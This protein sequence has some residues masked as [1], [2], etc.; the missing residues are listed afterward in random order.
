MSIEEYQDII[1]P[2]RTE[3]SN[4]AWTA[5]T[6]QPTVS[7]KILPRPF[8]ESHK[9]N[10][11]KSVKVMELIKEVKSRMGDC[12]VIFV[13]SHR[14]YADFIIFSYILF[15]YDIEI[16]AIAAGMDFHG[17]AGVG[18]MLRNTGAFFMRRTYN[19]DTL[20]WASFK[21]YVNSLVSKGDLPIEF[22]IEGTRSRSNKS[23]APKYGLI[24]MVLKAYFLKQVPD[25]M[26]V[27]VSINYDRILEETLFAFELL[28]I[29]KP[30][31][32]TS[33][34]FKSL[35]IVKERYGC[36]YFHFG[37]PIYVREFLQ[38][39]LTQ[40]QHSFGSIQL[41]EIS[42][43]EKR[44]IPLLAYEII[45]KQQQST[46]IS[47]FNLI[48]LILN[49]N[50][51]RGQELTSNQE[52]IREIRTLR[53]TLRSWGATI[54]EKHIDD[55]IEESLLVH[56]NLIR[57]DKNMIGLFRKTISVGNLNPEKLKAHSLSEV[58]ISYSVPFVMLQV[59][60]NPVLH[61]LVDAA[62]LVI[63]LRSCGRM[64]KDVLY[65]HFCILRSL[66][67]YE[68]ILLENLYKMH[69]E[70][71]LL[72]LS[73]EKLVTCKQG[74]YDI[75]ENNYLEEVLISS[76]QPFILTYYIVAEILQKLP[77]L[78][79]EKTILA[80]VQK[81]LE[82]AIREKNIFIHPYCMNLDSQG[83]CLN[84]LTKM[85]LLLKSKKDNKTIYKIN[86]ASVLKL[87]TDLE[88]YIPSF[89]VIKSFDIFL[90]IKSKI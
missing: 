14:S 13:P 22:F 70:E 53:E 73:N 11:F 32:S 88:T 5:R 83:N 46:V 63:I 79:D 1:Q 44:L 60:A 7:F 36:I 66:F 80:N 90:H 77:S 72:Q 65:S 54:F 38:D 39:K 31:E 45:R 25:I 27:P 2:R 29:P 35:K 37:E 51:T 24:N 71:A 34:F 43:A 55:E 67:F 26:L 48:A 58:I 28:G 10:V 50:L 75:Y 61:Y 74:Q 49:N 42:E 52:L 47:Y 19:N 9:Q 40:S 69:F 59:Y 89:H 64:D 33:G 18:E 57:R 23:I 85:G 16:P 20:Y 12:P 21:E 78:V 84:S 41:H 17:M 62:L 81:V 4:Y 76:I 30:K 6:L 56:Q 82:E 15:F 68:F 86:R 8:P 87:K 3:L